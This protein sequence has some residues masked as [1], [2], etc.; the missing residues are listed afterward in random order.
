MK[1]APKRR[2]RKAPAW[3]W[4]VVAASLGALGLSAPAALARAAA[5]SNHIVAIGDIH[6]D[7]DAFVGLLQHTRLVDG[8][9]RWIGGEITLVQTG[10]CVDR[11]PKVRDVLDLLMAL[12]QQAPSQGGRVVALLGNHESMNAMSNLRDTS[13]VSLAA[14]ADGESE[15]RREAAYAAH[16]KLA[17]TRAALLAK[18][19]PA[20]EIP[21]VYQV[22]ERNA[23]MAAHPP[24]FVEYLD[25]FGPQGTYGKWL[26]AHSVVIRLSDTVFLHG[27]I[28]P[29]NA[30]KKLETFTEQVQKEIARWDRMRKTMIEQQIALPSFTFEELLQ[31]GRSELQRVASE[32]RRRVGLQDGAGPGQAAQVIQQHPL[33]DLQELDK[34]VTISANGPLWFRGYATW[35]SDE[36][37]LRLN[38]LQ[39]KY[40]S[41]RFV[42]GHTMT[43]G[44]RVMPRFTSR[45]FLIDTGMLSSFYQGGRASALD[46]DGGVY[47][48][49]TLDGRQ[50]L[51][52][53]NATMTR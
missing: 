15:A 28:D 25:A 7:F 40:G 30:P 14:F 8:D 37:A 29:E 48:V 4:L 27:G 17:E 38:E 42:V 26:R 43:S 34:W 50:V 45:V 53:P 31:A 21:K 2:R 46:I 23:W 16:V 10:D 22:P 35:R 13:P 51:Y 1:S 5:K 20:I 18:A 3:S 52:D 19:D 32:A 33:A 6:G 24:G 39:R 9:R 49:V 44:F 41:V 12:E 11:G 47:T 36:G